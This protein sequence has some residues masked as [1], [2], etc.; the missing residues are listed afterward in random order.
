MPASTGTGSHDASDL[1]GSAPSLEADLR[2]VVASVT[3]VDAAAVKADLVGVLGGLKPYPVG[4]LPVGA[5]IGVIAA[6]V[7]GLHP[8]PITAPVLLPLSHHSS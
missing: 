3:V 6:P 1:V 8:S 4:H 7:S 2:H 5:P